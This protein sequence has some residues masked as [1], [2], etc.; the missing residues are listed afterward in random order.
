MNYN[1][2]KKMD[3]A[4]ETLFKQLE[5]QRTLLLKE[6]KKKEN[7]VLK[8]RPQGGGWNILEVLGH[9]LQTEKLALS[10]VN[11]KM[12]VIKEISFSGI[13]AIINKHILL[14]V[15]G[16]PFKYKAP[17]NSIPAED[18][19]SLEELEN[20]WAEFRK[21]LLRLLDVT[22]NESRKLLYRH[23]FAGRMNLLQMMQFFIAH[24][25]HHIKQIDRIQKG[26]KH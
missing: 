24:I 14:S 18:I 15:L 20:E 11:K 3:I 19:R 8:Q 9:L 2:R 16:L 26:I 25:K 6:L 23:P 7:A 1:K 4:S 12:N 13:K 22:G 17:Q 21:E 5:E 10:Y